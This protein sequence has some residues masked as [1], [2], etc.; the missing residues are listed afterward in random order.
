MEL[1]FSDYK[2]SLL[3]LIC[4]HVYV[5]FLQFCIISDYLILISDIGVEES[6]LRKTGQFLGISSPS[7][8]WAISLEINYN[9]FFFN[10]DI[11][12]VSPVGFL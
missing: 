8:Y 6:Y 3:G 9:S 12:V 10:V 7:T 2:A 11:D 4:F 1:L 5:I